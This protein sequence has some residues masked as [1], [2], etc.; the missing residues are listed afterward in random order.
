MSDEDYNKAIEDYEVSIGYKLS[1]N[2]PH[3][4]KFDQVYDLLARYRM[5]DEVNNEILPDDVREVI[6]DL[7][8]YLINLTGG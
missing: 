4:E 5:G 2:N 1:K 3:Q 7:D 6:K 8:T